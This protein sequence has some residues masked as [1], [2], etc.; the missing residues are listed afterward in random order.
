[1]DSE[2]SVPTRGTTLVMY[3]PVVQCMGS[4][5]GILTRDTVR[6]LVVQYSV[7]TRGAVYGLGVH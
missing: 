7:L 3:E 5:S 4:G 1:M 6:A 2:S